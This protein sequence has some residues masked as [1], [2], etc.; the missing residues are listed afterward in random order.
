M[1]LFANMFFLCV[2]S[3]AFCNELFFLQIFNEIQEKALA[4][5]LKKCSKMNYGLSVNNVLFLA[6]QYAEQCKV[7]RPK[8][9]EISKKATKD[10]YAGF[11]KR[12]PTLALRKPTPTSLARA[13]GFCKANVEEFY[14]NYCAVFDEK[15]YSPARIWNL[16]ETGCPTVP[17]IPGKVIAEKGSSVA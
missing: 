11:M 5:Y 17:T 1:C 12:N 7:P 9:W 8:G 14:T 10:W 16:D 13:K 2:M 3:N 15:I 4:N 6:Y